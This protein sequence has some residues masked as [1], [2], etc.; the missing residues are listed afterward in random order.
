MSVPFERLEAILKKV[1]PSPEHLIGALQGIQEEF[2]Y[3]PP[4]ALRAACRHVGVPE[5]RGWAV[6]T[7]YRFFNLEPR[8][9]HEV[10]VCM[11]TACHVRGAAKVYDKFRRDLEGTGGQSDPSVPETSLNKVYC[12]GCCSMGPIAKID[13][14]ILGNLDQ[15]KVGAFIET[16]IKKVL[17]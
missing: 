3:I 16:H 2:A 6:A 5:S 12:L 10:S 9:D 1:P 15:S 13:E 17:P 8:K 4:E 11:G 7:F 14:E